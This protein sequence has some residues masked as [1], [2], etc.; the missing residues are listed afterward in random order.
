[1]KSIGR[2]A[3]FARQRRKHNYKSKLSGFF[4]GSAGQE[5]QTEANHQHKI[6]IAAQT[7]AG[8]DKQ[9]DHADDSQHDMSQT[10]QCKI[11]EPET[12]RPDAV[13]CIHCFLDPVQI[14][15]VADGDNTAQPPAMQY[16]S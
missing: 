9:P 6:Q 14:R 12:P 7:A 11:A 1:L 15:P 3:S 8:V 5:Q 4:A 2:Q 13:V 16:R 10:P